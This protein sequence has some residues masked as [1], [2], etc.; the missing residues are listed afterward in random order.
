MHPSQSHK[1]QKLAFKTSLGQSTDVKN[2][3]HTKSRQPGPSA[4]ERSTGA[5][6]S[7]DWDDDESDC[8][9]EFDDLEEGAGVG[10]TPAEGTGHEVED[11]LG[12]QLQAAQG[13]EDE[14]RDL[15]RPAMGLGSVLS[16]RM[17]AEAEELGQLRARSG[18]S[19]RRFRRPTI[20]WEAWYAQ[21]AEYIY[22]GTAAVTS[23]SEG[24]TPSTEPE[25]A[26]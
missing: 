6:T 23:E 4:R 7:D 11:T 20:G 9:V 8:L 21:H 22:T 3:E 19:G 17:S 15:A 10:P 25:V 13:V 5:T 16:A 12:I 24:R 2:W 18:P 26:R 1:R 14:T